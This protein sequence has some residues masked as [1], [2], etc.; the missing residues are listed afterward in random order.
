MAAASASGSENMALEIIEDKLRDL[1]TSMVTGVD[2]QTLTATIQETMRTEVAGIR[3]EVAEQAGRITATE[4]AIAA[5]TTHVAST[6]T[7]VTRQGEMLLSLHRHLEDVDNRGR[8]CNIR[9]HG[10]PETEGEENAEKV[11]TELF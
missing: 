1:T 9:V 7:A 3:M 6:D 2:L 10:V 11:L 5:L 4:E 8:R